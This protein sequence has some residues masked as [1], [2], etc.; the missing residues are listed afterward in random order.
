[1]TVTNCSIYPKSDNESS[2]RAEATV[3]LDNSLTIHGL[4]IIDGKDGLFVAFPIRGV[5]KGSDGRKRYLDVV[6]PCN[7]ELRNNICEEVLACYREF[8]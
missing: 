5:T 7:D 8:N 6:H 2:V 4:R 3:T 1:M